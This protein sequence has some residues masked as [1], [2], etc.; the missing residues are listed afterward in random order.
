MHFEIEWVE[1]LSKSYKDFDPTSSDS[2]EQS[3]SR[4]RL[5]D[6]DNSEEVSYLTLPS[7]KDLL[8][9]HQLVMFSFCKSKPRNYL[10]LRLVKITPCHQKTFMLV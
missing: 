9:P 5:I 7:T 2:M 3:V 8:E 6:M 4:P 10:Y 1:L